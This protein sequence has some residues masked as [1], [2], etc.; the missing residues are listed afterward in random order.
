MPGVHSASLGV[1]ATVGA[2]DEP[3]AVAGV[4]HFLEHLVF[5]GAGERDARDIAIELDGVGG[6]MNAAT[7]YEQTGFEVTVPGHSAGLGLE[8]LRDVV[9]SPTL[10]VDDLE[11]ERQVIL[12]EFLALQDSP[13]DLVDS[14]LGAGLF[15]GHPLGVEVLGTR[16]TIE[17]LDRDAV[18]AFHRHWYCPRNLLV[19]AA[20]EVDHQVVVDQLGKA[21]DAL[22]AGELP[23]RVAPAPMSAVNLHTERPIEQLHL[24]MGVRGL[25]SDDPRLF[26][27][28]VGNHVLGR[29]PAS[30]LFQQVREERALAYSVY[31]YVYSFDDTGLLALYTATNGDRADESLALV[32]SIIDEL[33]A[34]GITEAEFERARGYVEGTFLMGLQTSAARMY[35]LASDLLTWDRVVPFAEDLALLRSMTLDDVNT[36]LADVLAGPRVT[37]T[38]G[39]PPKF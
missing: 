2:R 35:R 4:S 10:A 30:R 5:K 20:G 3:P 14:Q 12:E 26:A 38:V 37:S 33:A 16:E 9:T 11:S 21:L 15:P 34:N 32:T 28:R 17:A 39:P 25:A 1:W 18:T 6:S 19:V 36:V 13:E 8:L 27:L 29:G 23:Q 22:P 31:S 24:S 7:S